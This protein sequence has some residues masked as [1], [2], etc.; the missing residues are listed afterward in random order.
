M[1]LPHPGERGR[2]AIIWCLLLVAAHQL[3]GA[4]VIKAKAW[5]APILIQQAWEQTLL[6]GGEAVKPWPW[7]DT[8]PVARLWVPALGVERLVL[9]GDSGNAL[10]FGPGR[11]QAVGFRP[12]VYRLARQCG[13]DQRYAILPHPPAVHG[14]MQNTMGGF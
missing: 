2:R 3:G 13:L 6:S 4:A 9:A 12:F 5:L 7:A 14:L 11:V 8:W 1:F 10:A